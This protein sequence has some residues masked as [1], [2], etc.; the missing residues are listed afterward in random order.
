MYPYEYYSD[1]FV[2]LVWKHDFDWRLF[3]ISP[4]KAS[5]SS[6]PYISIGHNFLYGRMK[7]RSVHRN[8]NFSVPD[9]GYHE[10]GMLLNSLVRLKYFNVYHFTLN[11][12]YFY[13]WTPVWDLKRNGRYLIGM[14]I[15]L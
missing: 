4:P 10:S 14:G 3:S 9:N 11:A 13:H 8:V 15:D 6:S 7:D 2:S 12:G 5:L 1:E